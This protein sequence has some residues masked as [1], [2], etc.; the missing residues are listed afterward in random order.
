[1]LLVA[2]LHPKN[3]KT[4]SPAQTIPEASMAMPEAPLPPVI[5]TTPTGTLPTAQTESE[6]KTAHNETDRPQ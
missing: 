5:K 6:T 3:I 4:E 1:M 2:S